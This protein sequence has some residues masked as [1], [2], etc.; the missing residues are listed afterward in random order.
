MPQIQSIQRPGR[1]PLAGKVIH[2]VRIPAVAQ[3]LAHLNDKGGGNIVLRCNLG[4][5]DFGFVIFYMPQNAGN[6]PCFRFVKLIGKEE[7]VLIHRPSF[8]IIYD[9]RT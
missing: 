7:V 8:C 9:G 4:D 2:K 5:A 3:S 1:F 6:D